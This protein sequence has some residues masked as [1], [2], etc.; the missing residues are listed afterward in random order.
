MSR[1]APASLLPSVAYTPVVDTHTSSVDTAW[2]CTCT[3]VACRVVVAGE[4]SVCRWVWQLVW[5][6]CR[7]GMSMLHRLVR[8][9]QLAAAAAA[10][11]AVVVAIDLV[12]AAVA[13][14]VVAVV[15][16]IHGSVMSPP[17]SLSHSRH[18]VHASVCSH[19]R[20]AHVCCP[21]V[22]YT[23][24]SCVRC[25]HALHDVRRWG[26]IYVLHM[27]RISSHHMTDT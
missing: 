18:P 25:V 7:M 12:A 21:P 9:W 1:L 15:V 3:A 2:G 20:H 23:S 24:V 4:Q 5:G 6:R 16:H 13:V 8:T 11:A 10:A 22:W 26:R 17:P 27:D 19:P 14:A